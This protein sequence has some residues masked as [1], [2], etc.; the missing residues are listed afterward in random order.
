MIS[1]EEALDRILAAFSPLPAETV[2]LSEALGRVL[3][4]DVTA[5]VDQPPSAVSAMDGY[6]VRANDVSTVPAQ[7]TQIGEAPAGSAYDGVV[8]PGET[9]RIFTGAPLP[10]GADAIVIQEDADAQDGSEGTQVTMRETVGAGTF[11]RPAGLDFKRGDVGVPAG[12]PVTARDIGLA[13]AMNVPWLRVHRR[14]RV[15][16]L[17]TGDEI[18]MPGDPIGPNQ[19][20]SS[21]GLALQAFV[22]ASGGIPVHLG[23]AADSADSL[24]ALAE[25]A[26]GADLLVTTGGA[27]VGKHD[28][29][30]E[31]LVREGLDLDFW[32]IAMRP[33]KPLMFGR[34]GDT[35]M[36]GLPGNPVSSLV[37]A[38]LFVRP[39]LYRMQGR[40]GLEPETTQAVLT[41][42]LGANDRRQDYLRARLGRNDSGRLTATPFNRQDSSMLAALA[43]S[44][45]LI[46]RAPHA[47][48]L[49]IGSEVT[50]LP[51]A[52]GLLNP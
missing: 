11:V 41:S 12:K 4:E 44:D 9:V 52:G 51:I 30:R 28:L 29:V 50:V 21:N 13:A 32:K 31:V 34:I 42:A 2:G 8:G 35:P 5:R 6:A 20:V 25:G 23:I 47:E 18:V 3:A 17:G 38:L 1:V 22:T 16:I 43:H 37:C 45:A 49:D 14:P 46:V 33:G 19:I 7:L 39:A 40:S 24:S 10:E 15:A 27:S 36:L 48:P 26:R